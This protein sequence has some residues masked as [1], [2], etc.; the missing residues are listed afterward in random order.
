MPALTPSQTSRKR[1]SN[2]RV[3][4]G[5]RSLRLRFLRLHDLI[6]EFLGPLSDFEILQLTLFDHEVAV[7]IEVFDDVVVALFVVFQDDGFHGRVAFDEDS[8]EDGV[9]SWDQERQQTTSDMVSTFMKSSY[10]QY[11]ADTD[12][13]A[14]WLVATAK[15]CGFPVDKLGATA[16][17]TSTTNNPPSAATPGP[18]K[19]LEGKAR[20]LAREAATKAASTGS[21]STTSEAAKHILALKDFVDLAYIA[22]STKPVIRVPASFVTVLDRAIS[23]RREHGNKARAKFSTN[24][25]SRESSY[26]HEYFIGIL[27]HVRQALQPR[28]SDEN[29][30]DPSIDNVT[31]HKANNLANRFEGLEV[32]EPSEAFLQAPDVAIPAP[33]TEKPEV[34]YEAERLHDYEEVF[35][36]FILLLQDLRKIRAVIARTWKGYKLR[37]F[38]L[39][40]VSLMTNCAIDFAQHLEEEIQALLNEHG[41][42]IALLISLSEGITDMVGEDPM[43]R[44]R[45]GDPFN[46]RTYNIAESLASDWARKSAR[47][48]FE[49]DMKVINEVLSEFVYLH[50]LL[51]QPEPH[52]DEVTRGIRKMFDTHQVPLWLAFACQIFLDI[53]HC[54]GGDV[55]SGFADLANTAKSIQ[56]WLE[57]SQ[58]FFAHLRIVSWPEQ[59]DARIKR[60]LEFISAWVDSD[61]TQTAKERNHVWRPS[62]C[63]KLMKWHPLFCGILTYYIKAR[64][65]D[66]AM[67]FQGTWGAIMYA[68]HLCN[69]LRQEGLLTRHWAD[70]E[71]ALSWHNEIFVGTPPCQPSEYFKQYSLSIG[72]SAAA[73]AR[74]RRHSV[75]L[76]GSK[77]GPRRMQPVAPVSRMFFS[78]HCEGLTPSGFTESD[79]ET[80]LAK[81]AAWNNDQQVDRSVSKHRATR[82]D[83]GKPPTKKC[84]TCQLTVVELLETLRDT[85]HNEAPE[86]T[87]DYLALHRNCWRLLRMVRDMCDPHLRRVHGADSLEDETELP[88]LVGHFFMAA[89]GTHQLNKIPGR[90]GRGTQR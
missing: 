48:R 32:H 71:L 44:E 37:T 31:D 85:I 83:R 40:A 57:L 10:L 21:Q 15:S 76:P 88:F 22:A 61:F 2:I 72:L 50:L 41:G 9:I 56:S 55:E 45:P 3:Q 11:K 38:D 60:F 14:T 78:R 65:Q 58:E 89:G 34:N 90:E 59:Y 7:V 53:H 63:F 26:R 25:E 79:L 66:F 74:N 39:V 27:E 73:F 81:S 64:F 4:T 82:T 86:F 29:V 23:V 28:M 35:F 8:C 18:S 1:H 47:D 42:S 51:R 62:E 30:E 84:S 67:A 52:E 19:R 70:M 36:A 12:T 6:V 20:K 24:L 43:H 16:N 33:A 87:F 75:R 69:A 77:A 68:A 49:E 46:F 17:P 13:V 80:I 54:L 5:G